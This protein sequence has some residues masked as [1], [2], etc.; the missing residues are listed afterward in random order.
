MSWAGRINVDA[1]VHDEASNAIK[2]LDVESSFT[3]ATKTAIV[4]GTATEE[5]VS[6][7]PDDEHA[8]AYTDATG[9]VVTFSSVTML[10]VKGTD[11]LTVSVNGGVEFKAAAGQC[12]LS[13]TPGMTTE[14]INITGT[15]TFT[16][17]IVGT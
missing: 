6:I 14:T 4:T 9:A 1:L 11:A 7:S 10:L 16:L 8:I 13:A 12:A 5:G 2:V 17:L 3:V 15:G